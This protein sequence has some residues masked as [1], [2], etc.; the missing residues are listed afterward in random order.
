M[1]GL[2]AGIDH[3]STATT[4]VDRLLAFYK[5]HFELEPMAGFPLTGGDGRKIALIPLSDGIMLQATEVASLPAPE[6][7]DPPGAVFFGVSR[8]DHCSFRASSEEAFEDLR[9]RLVNAGASTG[10]VLS[11]GDLRFFRFTDPDGWF[12]E[13]VW[14]VPA[15]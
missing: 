14:H 15:A 11:S 12:A 7:I 8:F 1:P 13:V 4:D 2:I 5:D 10:T 3:V 9:I 6:P